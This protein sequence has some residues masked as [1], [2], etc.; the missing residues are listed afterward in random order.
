M[1]LCQKSFW[2]S[3]HCI[4]L[5]PPAIFT[6][7]SL[8]WLDF[9]CQPGLRP[10]LANSPAFCT[11]S[12]WHTHKWLD[13]MKQHVLYILLQSLYFCY[14][15]F[16]FYISAELRGVNGKAVCAILHQ[17]SLFSELV[18]NVVFICNI[19]LYI[20]YLS[21]IFPVVANTGN[22]ELNESNMSSSSSSHDR[23]LGCIAFR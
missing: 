3:S 23:R 6:C 19:L 8:N 18:S 2:S 13:M 21:I 17:R 12:I 10:Y 15:T 7:L 1:L 22:S 14:I 9:S 11:H 4:Y 20:F 5:F 16:P